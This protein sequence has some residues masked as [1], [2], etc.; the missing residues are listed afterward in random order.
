MEELNKEQKETLL[1]FMASLAWADGVVKNK[2]KIFVLG[3]RKSLGLADSFDNELINILMK[4]QSQSEILERWE[5]LKELFPEEV[6]LKLMFNKTL[7]DLVSSDGEI[8]EEE[9]ALIALLNDFEENEK[10]IKKIFF[11]NSKRKK[12][13]RKRK[14]RKKQTFGIFKRIIT[15]LVIIAIIVSLYLILPSILNPGL[16]SAVN[17]LN[18]SDIVYKEIIF[19]R[20]I[21]ISSYKKGVQNVHTA[22]MVIICIQGSADIEFSLKDIEVARN[23]N[24]DIVIT[25]YQPYFPILE[26]ELINSNDINMLRK[27][28]PIIVDVNINQDEIY[29]VR[30]LQPK[31]ISEKTAQDLGKVA[32]VIGAGAGGFAGLSLANAIPLKNPLYKV[33]SLAGGG[34]VGAAIAG[35]T[36]Y[37]ATTKFLTGL[38]LSS[39]ISQSD[40]DIAINESKKL[41]AAEILL[42]DELVNEL[43]QDYEIYLR[44]FFSEYEHNSIIIKYEMGKKD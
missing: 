17:K 35:T 29:E 21:V 10:N 19:E 3:K 30:N 43:R 22:K 11:S 5:D 39:E 25:V 26:K 15:L 24:N 9:A 20:Y 18:K 2:E 32:A 4:S 41:I 13:K 23:D 36:S 6:D 16:T 44:N 1:K 31:E 33:A 27:I 38:E 12:Y 8:N 28:T 37:V 34:L 40:K 14:N 7:L 42:D